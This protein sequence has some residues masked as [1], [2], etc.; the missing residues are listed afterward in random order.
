LVSGTETYKYKMEKR[1]DPTGL[2]YLLARMYDPAI[3]R[4]LQRD[5]VLGSLSASRLCK[6]RRV[7]ASGSPWEFHG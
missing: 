3:G 2:Y 4:L 1:G 6:R 5:P 7:N